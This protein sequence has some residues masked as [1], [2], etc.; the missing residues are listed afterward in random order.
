MKMNSTFNIFVKLLNGQAV[1]FN[2]SAH[3]IN[4]SHLFGLI[5]FLMYYL[6]IIDS[7]CSQYWSDGKSLQTRNDCFNSLVN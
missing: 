5:N 1:T 2:M 3:C 6:Y 4:T 7:S